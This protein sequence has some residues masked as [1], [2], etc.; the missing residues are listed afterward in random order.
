[1]K[2][3][4]LTTERAAPFASDFAD[5][6]LPR[7][8]LHLYDRGEHAVAIKAMCSLPM[9]EF[10]YNMIWNRSRS[11]F[12]VN[13]PELFDTVGFP[14]SMVRKVRARIRRFKKPMKSIVEKL[15]EGGV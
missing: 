6:E 10:Q 14:G 7:L 3:Q 13:Y 12:Y 9:P 8:P 11:R 15:G 5:G 1:M 2:Q 4:K